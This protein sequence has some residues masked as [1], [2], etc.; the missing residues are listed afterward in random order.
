MVEFNRHE[1]QIYIAYDEGRE[2]HYYAVQWSGLNLRS[3]ASFMEPFGASSV[4]DDR[5]STLKMD[6]QGD[7]LVFD[8]YLGVVD[9]SEDTKRAKVGDYVLYMQGKSGEKDSYIAVDKTTFEGAISHVELNQK[10][11]TGGNFRAVYKI[12]GDTEA[13]NDTAELNIALEHARSV[14]LNH[15]SGNRCFDSNDE[16]YAHTRI[17]SYLGNLCKIK[18][19]ET[20]IYPIDMAMLV[21]DIEDLKQTLSTKKFSCMQ[22]RDEHRQL[23]EWMTEYCDLLKTKIG[24]PK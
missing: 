16:F 17:C 20:P 7:V 15:I 11:D 19:R 2:L 1:G 10:L 8:R 5:I 3:I 12:V 9:N 22:C 6:L 18:N 14:C 23:L 13:V 24:E 4:I 21:V